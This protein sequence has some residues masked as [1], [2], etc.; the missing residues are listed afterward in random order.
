MADM[1]GWHTG[2][3]KQQSG[4][5]WE[6]VLGWVGDFS[7]ETWVPLLSKLLIAFGVFDMQQESALRCH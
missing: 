3:T 5:K 1:A 6:A 7:E 4:E 2:K